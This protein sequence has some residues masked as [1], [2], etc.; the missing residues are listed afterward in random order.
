VETP[1]R[2]HF[3]GWNRPILHGAA[4]WLVG[5]AK[6]GLIDL[7]HWLVVVPTRHAGRRLREHLAQRTG[8]GPGGVV[9][10]TVV[11]PQSII[12]M[13]SEGLPVAD[14]QLLLAVWVEVLRTLP[15]GSC[16]RLFPGP[17][18]RRDLAW[19]TASAQ[20]FLQVQHLLGERGL[21]IRDLARKDDTKE[22]LEEPER[23]EELA[24]IEAAVADVLESMGLLEPTP[25]RATAA[26]G[27]VPPAGLQQVAV[28]SVPDPIPLALTALSTLHGHLPVHIVVHAPESMAHAFDQWGRPLTEFWSHHPLL[29]DEA[30]IALV[31]GPDEMGAAVLE[32][33]E[34]AGI[35]SPD[36]V[37]GV[38]DGNVVPY[39]A[40][41]LG[42]AGLATHDPAGLPLRNHPL[43]ALLEH[44]AELRER[45][46]FATLATLL[47]HPDYLRLLQ[48]EVGDLSVHALLTELDLFQNAFLPARV[49]DV[50]RHLKRDARAGGTALRAAMDALTGHLEALSDGP[51]GKAL[52][53]FLARVYSSRQLHL[54]RPE[55]RAFQAAARAI[56]DL[57]YR[58][59]LPVYDQLS[60]SASERFSLLRQTLSG[61]YYY[62]DRE[63]EA[64]DLLGWLELH[65]DDAP[66]IVVTGMNDG[67][68]PEA[69]VG[70]AF[71]P[72]SL[73]QAL[74]IACN[75]SRF[76]RDAYLA[77]AMSAA[78]AQS[79]AAGVHFVVGKV[80]GSG[81]PMRPS[82][83]LFLCPDDTLAPRVKRLFHELPPS[84][85]PTATPKRWLLTP[86]AAPLPKHLSA[87]A[88]RDYLAC[89]FRFY[90]KRVL[91]L[92]QVDDRAQ[93]LDPMQFGILCHEALEALGRSKELADNSNE[94]DLAAFL[95]ATVTRSVARW[96]GRQV[97][98]AVQVQIES[99]RQRLRWAA[100]VEAAERD[101]GWRIISVESDLGT[102]SADTLGVFPVR[103]R[104]D[105]LDQHRDGVYRVLD[106]KTRE[107][108]KS[109]AES[110]LRKARPDTPEWQRVELNDKEYEW[111]DLQLPLYAHFTG[112]A[113]KAPVSAGIFE[114]PGAV[115]KTAV[116]IFDELG[117]Q[118][119]GNAI[120]CAE[121][122]ANAIADWRFWPPRKVAYDDYQDLLGP[123]P[124]SA[125]DVGAFLAMLDEQ[126]QEEK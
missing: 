17:R 113:L 28:L 79:E 13:G 41:S 108:S 34:N 91:R 56:S 23:W 26:L 63:P 118:L 95:D 106:Y 88:V 9:P 72:D 12:S 87:T 115:S 30:S 84:R 37:V 48:R 98:V 15:S 52:L 22:L 57:L 117:P 58:L 112:K 5:D 122:A 120:E 68:V 82:R 8:G 83:L 116:S 31:G 25:T 6:G 44:L 54:E 123:D 59:D 60:L 105:R 50:T 121:A 7:S 38:P 47:R 119:V 77:T 16:P 110:H 1:P 101:Q 33:L 78:R 126:R 107:K 24:K 45:G 75:A 20:R 97:P 125:V 40:K 69:I 71:L 62:L 99:A 49:S 85:V 21:T 90:L 64:V 53:Q 29:L 102:R 19:A 94:E 109:P 66:W 36:V 42:A 70:D 2:R 76:G 81:D 39:L 100:R 103:G 104:I 114:L 73:R 4:D 86:P 10:P 3:I 96:F 18:E 92:G 14:R 111:V 61:L 80:S 124:L 27:L 55:D 65:W 67:K 43:V 32:A 46:G 74:G 11:T 51:L 93:E 35:E 89:P